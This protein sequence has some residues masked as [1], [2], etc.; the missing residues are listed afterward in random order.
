MYKRYRF[1]TKSVADPRPLIDL[2][3]IQMP[4]WI[5]GEIFDTNTFDIVA[6]R[7]ICY[8]P[9]S[10]DLKKYWDDAFDIEVEDCESITYTG[11][12]PKPDWLK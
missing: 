3:G 10:E 8:L 7:I 11:R 2:K 4:Y 5:S 9:E 12:F 6:V 1:K